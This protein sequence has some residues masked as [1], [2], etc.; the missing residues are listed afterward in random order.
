VSS[1]NL[2][3]LEYIEQK[4]FNMSYEYAGTRNGDSFYKKDGRYYK[5]ERGAGFNDTNTYYIEVSCF[6]NQG[7]VM[8]LK[9]DL[10][11][12]VSVGDI[13]VG[14]MVLTTTG[15]QKVVSVYLPETSSGIY[16]ILRFETSL[17]FELGLTS[18]HLMYDASGKLKSAGRFKKNDVIQT[19]K[20]MD[21]IIRIKKDYAKVRSIVTMNGELFVDN[22]RVSSYSGN[23]EI[24]M[25]LHRLAAP[26]RL[27]SH[28]SP[29]LA[30]K[31]A[32]FAAPFLKAWYFDAKIMDC[33]LLESC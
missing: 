18:Q 8:T 2:I 21:T 10:E 6:W 1:K 23:E 7:K 11:R 4:F 15:Y 20:G 14:D 22:I 16:P 31:L 33:S 17:G 3:K 27:M 32:N 25:V 12:A 24:A 26:I 13:N 28:G 30:N 5:K 29:K 19:N 9:N